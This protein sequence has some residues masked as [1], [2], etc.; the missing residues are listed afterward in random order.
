MAWW[1]EYSN[2]NF[3]LDSDYNDHEL[4]ITFLITL[5]PRCGIVCGIAVLIL[6]D[7]TTE[8]VGGSH[9]VRDIAIYKINEPLTILHNNT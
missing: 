1:Q 3:L 6:F 2:A 5:S 9:T 7:L 4:C 8:S